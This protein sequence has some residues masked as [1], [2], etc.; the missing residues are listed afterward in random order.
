MCCFTSFPFT[1]TKKIFHST[2]ISDLCTALTEKKPSEEPERLKSSDLDNDVSED[3]SSVGGGEGN[4]TQEKTKKRNKRRKKKHV[5]AKGE[6]EKD[7]KNDELSDDESD[8][9]EEKIITEGNPANRNTLPLQI[10]LPENK[11]SLSSDIVCVLTDLS[12]AVK[13]LWSSDDELTIEFKNNFSHF[14]Q[15]DGTEF[16]KFRPLIYKNKKI[17]RRCLTDVNLHCQNLG[18]CNRCF[19]MM[20]ETLSYPSTYYDGVKCI[21][22]IQLSWMAKYLFRKGYKLISSCSFDKENSKDLKYFVLYHCFVK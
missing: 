16:D 4:H 6:N 3:K 19:Q 8:D 17:C 1:H 20:N 10:S 12:G 14:P 9:V 13:Q 22:H 11:L 15:N 2:F 5:L 7:S 21:S 18:F